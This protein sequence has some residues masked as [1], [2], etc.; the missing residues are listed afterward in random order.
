MCIQY[1][2]NC[3]ADQNIVFETKLNRVEVPNRQH[4][5]FESKY[6]ESMGKRIYICVMITSRR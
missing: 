4:I 6:R 1:S 2:V 5:Y 3:I